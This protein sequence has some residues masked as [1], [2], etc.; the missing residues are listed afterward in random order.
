MSLS[1]AKLLRCKRGLAGESASPMIF[2]P[3]TGLFGQ[4]WD[5]INSDGHYAIRFEKSDPRDTKFV[6]LFIPGVWANAEELGAR[7]TQKAAEALCEKHASK[8]LTIKTIK[9]LATGVF[10]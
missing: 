4:R 5:L 6:A 3:H 8:P 7:P 2:R 1:A 10:Q 9:Y